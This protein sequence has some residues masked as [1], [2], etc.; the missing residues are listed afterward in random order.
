VTDGPLGEHSNLPIALLVAP[1]AGRLR[2]L[3]PKMFHGGQEWVEQGQEVAVIE[4][5]NGESDPVLAPARGRLGGLMGRDG[6]P[7]RSGQP[8]AWMEAIGDETP[9]IKPV[10]DTKGQTA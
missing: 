1:K 3:K 10:P 7:V 4:H 9:W 5:G 8:V 6:E 2:I